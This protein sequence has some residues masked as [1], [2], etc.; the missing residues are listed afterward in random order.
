MED[1]QKIKVEIKNRL[2]HIIL[3]D[4]PDNYLSIQ[5]LGEL[6]DTLEWLA[7]QTDL[8]AVMFS[9]SGGCFTSGLDYREHSRELVF[10]VLERFRSICNTML[11]LEFP[12]L[13][14]VDG[15]V[16]NWGCD[17]LQFFDLVLASSSSTFQYDNLSTGTFP[18]LGALALAD[19]NGL[20]PALEC[21]LEGAEMTAARAQELGLISR[22]HPR[23]AIVSELKKTMGSFSG[24]STPV[25]SILLRS[26]RRRKLEIFNNF[27]DESFSDYL[28][29]L[30]DLED[31]NEGIAAW[32]EKRPPVW[33]NR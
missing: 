4:P 28:N 8:V 24:H 27:T 25:L 19:R 1:L 13:A 7:G 6:A 22:M 12:S 2:A 23:E 3:N 26:L 33:Q 20:Q 11:A 5:M 21:L 9:A 30:T 32:C 17:L 14:V 16:R 31:F 15:K 18:P 29:L 10:T